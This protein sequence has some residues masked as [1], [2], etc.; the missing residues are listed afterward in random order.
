MRPE[1]RIRKGG[2]RGARF[3]QAAQLR[4]VDAGILLLAGRSL[5]ALYL[6]GYAVECILKFAITRRRTSVYLP[7]EFEIHSW[8]DLLEEAGLAPALKAQPTL[9]AIFSELAD[10]WKPELRYESKALPPGEAMRLYEQIKEVYVWIQ[11]Q[12]L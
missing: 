4:L 1:R 7:E 3:K 8:D 11:E 6:A 9:Q 5:G 2:S 10:F 12:S